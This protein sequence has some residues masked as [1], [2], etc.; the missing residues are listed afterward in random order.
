MFHKESASAYSDGNWV[1]SLLRWALQLEAALVPYMPSMQVGVLF[2]LL[3]PIIIVI[4]ATITVVMKM[5]NAICLGATCNFSEEIIF[6]L[7][8]SLE[9]E[10]FALGVAQPDDSF[11]DSYINFEHV[12]YIIA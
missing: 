5:E 3:S 6:L 7:G 10:N 9:S 4:M 8:D 11:W 2:E 12:C 1:N